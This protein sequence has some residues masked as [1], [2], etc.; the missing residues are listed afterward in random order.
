MGTGRGRVRFG[1]YE[2]TIDS[3]RTHLTVRDVWVQRAVQEKDCREH[4]PGMV[5][6][7]VGHVGEAAKGSRR[8]IESGSPG[9]SD[10]QG[11]TYVRSTSL[12]IS[13]LTSRSL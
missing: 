5:G 11:S 2:A 10:M 9:A 7:E 3:R 1:G 6:L 12:R 8:S 4:D 13:F